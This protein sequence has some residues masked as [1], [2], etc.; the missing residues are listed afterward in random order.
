MLFAANEKSNDVSSFRI[1]PNS[2]A[3][4]HLSGSPS[5]TGSSPT[6]IRADHTIIS[7]TSKGDNS[8]R[9]YTGQP[10]D[11]DV[12]PPA[13]DARAPG[14]GKR[15]GILRFRG[16]L[17][18]TFVYVSNGSIA[19]T[20]SAYSAHLGTGALSEIAGSPI[21]TSAVPGQVAVRSLRPVS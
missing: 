4:S 8:L 3:L 20:I 5:P 6:W 11:R 12:G 15:R 7:V 2:G 18:P 13:G 9:R 1:D 17:R 14:A 21:A 19:N 16:A 10:G